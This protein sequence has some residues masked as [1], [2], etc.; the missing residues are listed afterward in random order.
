MCITGIREHWLVCWVFFFG[1]RLNN[2]LHGPDVLGHETQ[3]LWN[4]LERQRK[5]PALQSLWDS[6]KFICLM[7]W[8]GPGFFLLVYFTMTLHIHQRLF[9]QLGFLLSLSAVCKG[10][11]SICQLLLPQRHKTTEA[12]NCYPKIIRLLH[13]G[14]RKKVVVEKPE[15]RTALTLFFC[16]PQPS[17]LLQT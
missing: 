10:K 9:Q 14:R 3:F 11:D 6:S 4:I 1:G 15:F 12:Q 17:N 2:G 16:F 13:W 5:E 7:T 8:L